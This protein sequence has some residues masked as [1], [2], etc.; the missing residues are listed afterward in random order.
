[1]K[2]VYSLLEPARIY[3]YNKFWT[4]WKRF[5]EFFRI[6]IQNEDINFNCCHLTLGQVQL[7]GIMQSEKINNKLRE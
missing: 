6:C 7:D 4:Y 2:S 3:S 1:M 5:N